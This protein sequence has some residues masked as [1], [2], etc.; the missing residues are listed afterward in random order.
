MAS[1]QTKLKLPRKEHHFR[2]RRFARALL[3]SKLAIIALLSLMVLPLSAF[4]AHF[5]N[6]TAAIYMIDPP[7]ILPPGGFY[8]QPVD[9]TIIDDDPDATHIF[10]TVTPGMD[11]SLAPDPQCGIYPGGVK[12][13]GPFTIFDDSVIKAIACDGDLVTS[14]GSLITTEIYDLSLQGKI[15]GRKYHDLDQSGTLTTGDFAI[16]GW[17]INLYLDEPTPVFLATT[18][19]DATGYYTFNYLDPDS[20]LVIEEM[21]AGWQE[22]SPA[23]AVVGLTYSETETVNFF[24][25]DTGYSC[26]PQE[27][28]FPSGLAVQASGASDANDDVDMANNVTINGSV[29]S[30]DEIE[31]IT[32]S[33]PRTINGDA[34]VTNTIDAGINVT[35]TTSPGA[36]TAP[37]PDVMIATWKAKAQEGGTVN[38]SLTFPT[39]NLG[40]TMGPAEI[41]GNVSF[42]GSNIV[43]TVKGPLYIHGNLTIDSNTAIM[44]DVAFGNQFTTIIV[45][46]EININQN[47]S[48]NGASTIGTFLLLSTHA[49]IAGDDAAINALQNNSDLGDV[50][51]YASD[52]DIH[53][54]QNRTLLALFASHGTGDDAD[55]NGAIRIDQNVDVNYRTLPTKIS[56]GPRQ[57]FASTSHVLINEFMPNPVG[58]DVGVAGAPVDGEWVE[59]FNPTGATVD[60]AGYVLYDNN[61][62]H[63]LA[64]SGA[65]TDTGGTT[66]PSLGYLVVYRDGDA[67]FEL[68]NTGGD[69]VRL[70]TDTIG[71]GGVLVDNHVYTRNADENKS[72]ARIPDGSTNWVDPDGTPGE[73]NLSFFEPLDYVSVLDPFDPPDLPPLIIPDFTPVV[74]G[75]ESLE[76]TQTEA[77]PP[78]DDTASTSETSETATTT[79]PL[80]NTVTPP[81]DETPPADTSSDVPPAEEPAPADTTA[82]TEEPAPATEPDPAPAPEP[83]PPPADPAP[84]DSGTTP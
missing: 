80:D 58:D 23:S 27:V 24:N 49:A 73:A 69:E 51:L 18:V 10:Y 13:I 3:T 53:I 15:E 41:L 45:D 38:G 35:G 33:G 19:T 55:D 50:V 63:T 56:C 11:D 43:V 59:I 78:A 76:Q 72:F 47:A 34:T 81:A 48:F 65:N 39:N 17:R 71:G 57:P 8:T 30:N 25:Y 5:I 64:I 14:H 46:G 84:T 21:L 22:T 37:L 75:F 67:D 26:V 20:Y 44:Q 9:I 4:E 61:N 62:T 68:Q 29:R 82:P 52:G 16:E 42:T 79:D 70:F 74:A 66:I 83:T 2:A 40:L 1:K 28:S 12:P 32:S 54:E 77:P 60:V 6:V 36:P 7:T 31:E